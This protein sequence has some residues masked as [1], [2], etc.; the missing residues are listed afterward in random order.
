[1]PHKLAATFVS[2]NVNF[3]AFLSH[4]Q[5]REY[6]Y[7]ELSMLT[8][9]AQFPRWS[10]VQWLTIVNLLYYYLLLLTALLSLLCYRHYTHLLPLAVILLGTV[11]MLLVGHGEARFHQPFM[12]FVIMLSA[13][14][15]NRI[16]HHD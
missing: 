2:D 6:M 9:K 14:F 11:M 3:C 13:Q 1:M 16:R 4:K 15:I 12:P 10:A 8:L 7:D 5:Q